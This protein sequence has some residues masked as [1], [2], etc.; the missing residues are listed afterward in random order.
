MAKVITTSER[1][2]QDGKLLIKYK[3][4][5]TIEDYKV[6]KDGIEKSQ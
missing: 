5:N 4:V 3:L 1:V 6:V 2:L